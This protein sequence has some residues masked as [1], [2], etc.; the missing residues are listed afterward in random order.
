MIQHKAT[1]H[2]NRPVEQVFSFLTDNHNL[3][4]W[5]SNLI[6]SEQLTD[7][8]MRVGTR[9]REVRRLGRRPSEIQAEITAFEPNRR[10]A[11][12]TLIEPLVTVSYEFEAEDS[13]T[14]LTYTFVMLTR[15]MMRLLQPLISG[16]IK[17]Q[18]AADFEKLKQVLER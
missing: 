13:G 10:F 1:V 17:K 5:Q 2:L 7:G 6:E 16:S 8:P 11:T 14:R 3:R 18:T 15:G 9:I 4:M 12:K